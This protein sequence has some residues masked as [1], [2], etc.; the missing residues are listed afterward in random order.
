MISFSTHTLDSS[1]G[2]HATGINVKLSIHTCD[3]QIEEL[4]NRS[5]DKGGRLAVNFEL[6]AKFQN[7]E[8]QLSF[9]IGNYFKL[10][11]SGIQ[12][13]SVN[14]IIEL[15][16]LNGAYHLPIIVSP[17]GASLWWSN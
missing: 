10:S 5:T 14:L 6:D 8:F 2:N 13:K 1:T 17:Y 7:C 3:N 12:M 15:P 4:W 9:D 16:D 11:A